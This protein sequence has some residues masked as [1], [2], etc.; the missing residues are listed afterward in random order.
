[1]MPTLRLLG[2]VVAL[3]AAFVSEAA[4]QKKGGTLTVGTELD[5]TGFDP[6]TIGVFNSASSIAASL[7]FDTLTWRDDE[8]NVHPNLALS[9]SHS[10]DFKT[11]TIELRSGVK[12]HDGTPYNA[13]AVAWNYAR[14]KDPG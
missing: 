6:L 3:I 14:M 7:L 5:I 12:F 11:W 8:G 9:W 4:G 10:D 13:E 2:C 1:M